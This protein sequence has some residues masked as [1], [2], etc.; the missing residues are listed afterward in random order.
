MSVFFFMY[1][2]GPFSAKSVPQ[3]M[4]DKKGVSLLYVKKTR[5]AF[6]SAREIIIKNK[7]VIGLFLF[8]YILGDIKNSAIVLDR[9]WDTL[10]KS[11]KIGGTD[12]SKTCTQ[13]K[14]N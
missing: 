13:K 1:K 11:V 5:R 14:K 3:K 2:K 10:S 6:I 4:S 9:K 7:T 8:F 12:F